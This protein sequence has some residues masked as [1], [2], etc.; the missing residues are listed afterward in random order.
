M[1]VSADREIRDGPVVSYIDILNI[2]GV[3]VN[4]LNQVAGCVGVFCSAAHC[5]LLRLLGQFFVAVQ[6]E[7]FFLGLADNF[8]ADG[9]CLKLLQLLLQLFLG[10]E[11]VVVV[12]ARDRLNPFDKCR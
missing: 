6:L 10:E 1:Y 8:S 11:I 9:A 7:K 3:V 12:R 2:S 4:G 5:E